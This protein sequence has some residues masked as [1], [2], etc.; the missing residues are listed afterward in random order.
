MMFIQ[1][2]HAFY[3]DEIDTL[4]VDSINVHFHL[5]VRIISV[6]VDDTLGLLLKAGLSFGLPPVFDLSFLFNFFGK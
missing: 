6:L 3:I 2:T 1:K 4:I 5:R